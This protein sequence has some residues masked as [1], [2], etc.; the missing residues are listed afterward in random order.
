MSPSGRCATGGSSVPYGG[1]R[2]EELRH[3]AARHMLVADGQDRDYDWDA[4]KCASDAPQV[5][6]EKDGE[7]HHE[8]R[9]GENAA[10]YPRL[11]VAAYKELD[12]IQT[13][14][15]QDDALP[16]SELGDGKNRWQYRCDQRADKWNIV[17][18]EGD[19]P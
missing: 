14:E 7:Q 13:G 11:K 17:E 16:G 6:P 5:G 12:E 10:R 19:I 8:R 2:S 1:R 9:H 3:P 18:R 15:Y 4:D